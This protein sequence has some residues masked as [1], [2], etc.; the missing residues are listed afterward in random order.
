MVSPRAVAVAARVTETSNRSPTVRASAP[1]TL[2][3]ASVED[4]ATQAQD[5]AEVSVAGLEVEQLVR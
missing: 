1:A 3:A 2:A 5:L 4:R